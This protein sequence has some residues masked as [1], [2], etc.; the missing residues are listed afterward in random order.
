MNKS[1]GYANSSVS[2]TEATLH[3]LFDATRGWLSSFLAL[4]ALE[5]KKAGI[6]LALMVGFSVGATA[7]AFTG[8]L[9]LVGCAVAAL[10]EHNILG[11]V[12]SMLA[13]ALLNFCGAGAF[14]FLA[15]RR[16][17]DLMF[18]ATRHQLGMRSV[19]SPHHE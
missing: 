3:S 19:D 9:A 8:W 17:R 13:V 15:I 12:W 11:W 14:V 6:G 4:A 1:S 18:F 16:K 2:P 10:V 7:L 5:G